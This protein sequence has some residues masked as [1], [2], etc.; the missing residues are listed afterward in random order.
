MILNNQSYATG[1]RNFIA[2]NH[3]L[4][5]LFNTN[6]IVSK[7]NIT[8]TD[9]FGSNFLGFVQIQKGYLT[10]ELVEYSGSIFFDTFMTSGVIGVGLMVFVAVLSLK[11]FKKY[12][13]E[14]EATLNIKVTLLG[15]VILYIL[16]CALFYQGEYGVYYYIN[17][18][19]F[20]SGPFLIVLFILSYVFS[21]RFLN[22]PSKKVEEKK[23]EVA[24]EEA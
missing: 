1:F 21:R 8:L 13:L 23:E 7:Y 22:I 24:D 12:I 6:A 19:Y 11:S 4:N 5:R 20:M 15:L 14:D 18:P 10:P 16:Y 2:G 9:V 17:T 3:F